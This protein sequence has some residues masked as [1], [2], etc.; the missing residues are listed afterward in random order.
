MKTKHTQIRLMALL[1]SLLFFSNAWAGRVLINDAEQTVT[2]TQALD[3]YSAADIKI[4]TSRPE[5]YEPQSGQLQA[6]NDAVRAMLSY[7]CPGLSEINI[8]GSVR[9]LDSIVYQGQLSAQNSWLVQTIAPKNLSSYTN[10]QAITTSEQTY[11]QAGGFIPDLDK[12]PLSITRLQLGMSAE[13]VSKIVSDT[14]EINPEYKAY[15][16]TMT[17]FAGGCPEDFD[18]RR[19]A[20]SAQ[21]E[22]KCLKA[23]FSDARTPRLE[24]LELVQVANADTEQ[25]QQLLVE[26]YGRPQQTEV[27]QFDNMTQL[28]W[29]TESKLAIAKPSVESLKAILSKTRTDLVI[30][31]L[32]LFN[33][34]SERD[35]LSLADAGLKL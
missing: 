19:N 22:W 30:T 8:T 34:R 2:L 25:V 32:T 20:N 13:E 3:C 9:G 18:A 12:E 27:S 21:Q 24:R 26:K 10:S 29:R 4:N 14:F 7:E 31:S 35:L 33:Q 6:I 15:E 11:R 28:I 5:I 17:M 1:A 16:G 23:W